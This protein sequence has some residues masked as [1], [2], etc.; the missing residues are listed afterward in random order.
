MQ[1]NCSK[2]IFILDNRKWKTFHNKYDNG[3]LWME[4]ITS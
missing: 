3:K 2:K 4:V 1:N